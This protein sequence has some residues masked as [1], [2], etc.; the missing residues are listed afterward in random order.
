MRMPGSRRAAAI[1][2]QFPK[3]KSQLNASAPG[4]KASLGV[5]AKHQH[6]EN[7]LTSPPP[8]LGWSKKQYSRPGTSANWGVKPPSRTESVW[9]QA[10]TADLQKSAKHA[11]G[12][13]E[14][15]I[16]V[17][18][19]GRF[20]LSSS[21]VTSPRCTR[22]GFGLSNAEFCAIVEPLKT[23]P[24]QREE[25]LI[26]RHG[27]QERRRCKYDKR[28]CQMGFGLV[29]VCRSQCL[30]SAHLFSSVSIDGREFPSPDIQ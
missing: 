19:P 10:W 22:R 21:D 30:L 15:T 26:R 7:T 1:L 24:P 13:E 8:I 12:S 6:L 17:V 25:M 23:P 28:T 9:S 16:F 5:H 20:H 4:R 18:N 14:E 29:E 3:E 11:D 2:R 27:S